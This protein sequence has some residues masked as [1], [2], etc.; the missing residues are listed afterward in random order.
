MNPS[1]IPNRSTGV[2]PVSPPPADSS[3]VNNTHG[4]DADN[5]GSFRIRRGASL[6][7]WRQ[8]GAIYAVTFRLADSVP[9]HV[10]DSWRL[11][12]ERP[13]KTAIQESGQLTADES[14]RLRI[15]FS[16][17]VE[18]YLNRRHGACWMKRN[19]VASVV[20]NALLH[21]DGSRYDL[22]TWCVMPNHVHVVVRPQPAYSLE[23]IMHSWKSFTS[24]MIASIVGKTGVLWQTEY[25]DHLVRNED[26]LIHAME[27]VLNNPR[28]AGLV[29]WPW[30]GHRNI[31]PEALSL[32]VARASRP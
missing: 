2:P 16:E 12:R 1:P 17:K 7:H 14:E 23:S 21:F 24:K 20:Q 27:Y 3:P 4:Q 31:N 32:T 8:D 11:E 25:Y 15:L 10:L 22:Y 13:V 29:N 30:V 26:D 9:K 5:T 28:V 19:E 18:A 6:P